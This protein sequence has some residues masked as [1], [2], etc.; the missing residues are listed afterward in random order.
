[1][2]TSSDT[3]EAVPQTL[4]Y[5]YIVARLAL[6][7]PTLLLIIFIVGGFAGWGPVHNLIDLTHRALHWVD[8]VTEL[9]WQ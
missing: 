3:A 2:S 7:I 1:V 8:S 4:P 9:H 6:V 5:T